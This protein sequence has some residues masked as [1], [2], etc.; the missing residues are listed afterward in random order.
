MDH[1][2]GTGISL[3]VGGGLVALAAAAGIAAFSTAFLAGAGM[4]CLAFCDKTSQQA[5]RVIKIGDSFG[6]L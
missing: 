5:S 3:G 2:I 6:N 4:A 1:P